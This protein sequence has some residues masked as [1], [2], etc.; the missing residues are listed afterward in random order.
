MKNENHRMQILFYIIFFILTTCQQTSNCCL[1]I[2]NQKS[3]AQ[4]LV[5]HPL[6]ELI[7]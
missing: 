2:K 6:L 1:N 3:L 4:P 5:V 7:N